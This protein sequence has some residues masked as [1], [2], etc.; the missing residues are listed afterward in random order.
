MIK[1]A[2]YKLQSFN[3][4]LS[5]QH[6]RYKLIIPGNHDLK[7]EEIIVEKCNSAEKSGGSGDDPAPHMKDIL[8]N[9]TLLINESITIDG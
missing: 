3:D 5:K 1:G 7:L 4:W 8:S 2:R 6:A 9:G